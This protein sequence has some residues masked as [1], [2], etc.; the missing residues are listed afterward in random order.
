MRSVLLLALLS[1]GC[2]EGLED[3]EQIEDTDDETSSRV[4]L[5]GL[6]ALNADMTYTL[7]PSLLQTLAQGSLRT[8]ATRVPTLFATAA[9]RDQFSYLYTCAEKSNAKLT[10]VAPSGTAYTYNGSLGLATEW[11]SGALPQKKYGLMTAC[12]LAR[13]NYFGE[14]VSISMRNDK[15]STR[16]DEQEAFTVPEGAFWGDLFTGTAMRACTSATKLSGAPISTL[17]QRECTVSTD[18]AT[19]KCGFGYAGECSTVCVTDLTKK[20]GY[21]KCEGHADSISVFVAAP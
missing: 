12:M 11:T 2:V 3:A 10:V 4:A 20:N 21:S 5:N 19:T 9:G 14:V 16:S 7:D 15:I 1:G 13:T 8:A 18:G 17:P 6:T